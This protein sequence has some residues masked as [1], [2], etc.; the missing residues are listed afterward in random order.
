MLLVTY[1]YN[2]D[3]HNHIMLLWVLA[4]LVA[5]DNFYHAIANATGIACRSVTEE[6][7]PSMQM[8]EEEFQE[9]SNCI[10]S[11]SEEY[12]VQFWGGAKHTVGFLGTCKFLNNELHM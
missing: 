10:V 11:N 8:S 5:R 1:V 7:Q 4:I 12:S 6:Q 2:T 3:V 9:S